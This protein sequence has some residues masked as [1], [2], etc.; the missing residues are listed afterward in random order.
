MARRERAAAGL[1]ER[2]WRVTLSLQIDDGLLA[3]S[4]AMISESRHLLAALEHPPVRPTPSQ[5]IGDDAAKVGSVHKQGLSVRVFENALVFG[6]TLTNP[7]NEM[8]G[9]GTAETE[10]KARVEAFRAGMTYIDRSKSRSAP[11]NIRFH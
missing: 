9:C 1:W 10:L 3:T 11:D 5:S 8:L 4:H 6:W 2:R 7:A